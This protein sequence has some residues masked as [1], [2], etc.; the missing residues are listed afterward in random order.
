TEENCMRS[1]FQGWVAVL[2]VLPSGSALAG[3]EKIE[4]S[5]LPKKIVEAVKAKYPEALLFTATKEVE[6]KE[7][8]YNVRIKVKDQRY[9]VTLKSD[10]TITEVARE[11]AVKDLPKDVAEAIEKKFAQSTITEAQEVTAGQEI[12]YDVVVQTADKKIIDVT[13]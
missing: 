8:W 11:I 9:E 4:V 12:T 1:V 5:D 10:G 3:E 13:L 7:T 2:L 6:G